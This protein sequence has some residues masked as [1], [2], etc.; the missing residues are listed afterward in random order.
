MQQVVDFGAAG[1]WDQAHRTAQAELATAAV[2]EHLGPDWR[3]LHSLPVGPGPTTLHHLVIGPDGVF[4]LRSLPHRATVV[5]V[6]DGRTTLSTYGS[7]DAV[8]EV[9]QLAQR[10]LAGLRR[11]LGRSVDIP[12]VHPLLCLT[13]GGPAGS[14][15]AHED[16]VPLEQLVAHLLAHPRRLTAAEVQRLTAVALEPSTWDA[17]GTEEI[18]P[19]VAARYDAV[20]RPDGSLRRTR[21]DADDRVVAGRLSASQPPQL[22]A[23]APGLR[24]ASVLLVLFGMASMGTGGVLSPPTLAFGGWTLRHYGGWKWLNDRDASLLMVGMVMAV[25]P[26]P[27]LVLMLT[28][29]VA[30][31]G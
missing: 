18:L 20:T 13:D 19:D 21:P 12:A 9:R 15:G 6:V 31:G 28:T 29:L 24:I 10:V 2:L 11:R 5:D 8:A 26:L 7:E 27:F 3:V 22:A 17:P 1:D 30:S 25:L 4:A 23:K 16:V 14:L